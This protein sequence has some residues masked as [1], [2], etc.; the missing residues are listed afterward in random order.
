[1]RVEQ[2]DGEYLWSSPIWVDS[3]AGGSVEG[4]PAWNAPDEVDLAAVGENEA[5]QYLPALQEYLRREEK[6][7]AFE[8]LTPIRV[9]R[10]PLG[11]YAVFY[12]YIRGHRVLIQWFFEFEV[13][14]M[15]MEYGWVLYG[16]EM[17]KGQ[18]WARPLAE[19]QDTLGG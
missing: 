17:V 14:R 7:E 15:R 4:L 5:S 19:G 8:R 3:T 18:P 13:P 1:M 2:S 12:C 6:L 9:V 10:A 11:D 16:A